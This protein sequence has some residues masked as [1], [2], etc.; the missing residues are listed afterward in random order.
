MRLSS[1]HDLI[2]E[3]ISKASD[4]DGDGTFR[5]GDP[6]DMQ[7]KREEKRQEAEVDKSTPDGLP[8]WMEPSW[9][10]TTDRKNPVVRK[11]K[12]PSE[13]GTFRGGD[14]EELQR[15]REEKRQDMINSG[16]AEE[17]EQAAQDAQ[18]SGEAQEEAQEQT[19]KDEEKEATK[20]IAVMSSQVSPVD[21][22]GDYTPR[23]ANGDPLALKYGYERTSDTKYKAPGP[24]RPGKNQ[25]RPWSEVLGIKVPMTNPI[26]EIRRYLGAGDRAGMEKFT[27]ILARSLDGATGILWCWRPDFEG[28]LLSKALGEAEAAGGAPAAQEAPAAAPKAPAAPVAAAA[29]QKPVAAPEKQGH[30]Y[31]KRWWEN[32]RWQYAYTGEMHPEGH[33]G[34]Q[35][36]GRLSGHTMDIHPETKAANVSSP[37]EAYHHSRAWHVAEGG[38]FPAQLFNKDTGK[39]EDKI[40][41]MPGSARGAGRRGKGD[42]PGK[43]KEIA[44]DEKGVP[45]FTKGSV[46]VYGPGQTP[47]KTNVQQAYRPGSMA[48]FERHLLQNQVNTEYDPHGQPW[49]H[50]RSPKTGTGKPLTQ[51]DTTS[52]YGKALAEA[53]GEEP[54]EWSRGHAETP[55]NLRNF[56]AKHASTMRFLKDEE[57]RG[58]TPPAERQKLKHTAGWEPTS[59]VEH[60]ADWR[61]RRGPEGKESRKPMK[62]TN[63]LEHGEHGTWT[64]GEA[65]TAVRTT[66]NSLGHEIRNVRMAPKLQFNS[67]EL[68]RKVKRDIQTE[69]M[70]PLYNMAAYGVLRP[71]GLYSGHMDPQSH[72]LAK[73]LA[74]HAIGA[75]VEHAINTYNPHRGRFQNHL[76]NTARGEMI[77]SLPQ[78]L[79]AA[80]EQQMREYRDQPEIKR[81]GAKAAKPKG[82]MQVSAAEFADPETGEVMRSPKAGAV[83]YQEPEVSWTA[84]PAPG[85]QARQGREPGGVGLKMGT[86]YQA[87]PEQMVARQQQLQQTQGYQGAAHELA[88][89]G[90]MMEPE[91]VEAGTTEDPYAHLAPP[92]IQ[93][94]RRK[95]EEAYRQRMA[96][97]SRPAA[98]EPE[99]EYA[100][101][102]ADVA[103]EEYEPDYSQYEYTRKAFD[104]LL[105]EE[106]LDVLAKAMAGEPMHSN[107]MK[108]LWREGEPGAHRHMWEDPQGNVVRG[109]NAPEG[110]PHHDPNA[111]PPQVHP[112]EPTP[113]VAP[114]FFDHRGRKLNRPA[115]EGAEVEDNNHYDPDIYHWAQRYQDP[116]TGKTEH[117]YFHRDCVKDPR[118]KFNEDLKHVDAQLE[119]VRQWYASLFQSQDPGERALGLIMALVDQAKMVAD[120]DESGLL[121]IKVKDVA[122]QG[123][124]I[125]FTYK[126]KTGG[127]HQS[128]VTMD[129]ESSAVLQEL[130]QG[131]SP[132][133]YLFQINGQRIPQSLLAQ[134][135]DQQ[136]GLLLNQFRVYHGSELFSK[137]FQNLVAKKANLKPNNLPAI[138]KQAMAQVA[139][140]LGHRG[141]S[142]HRIAQELY[143]DPLLVEALYI[144]AIHHH[145]PDL[146]KSYGTKPGEINIPHD[147]GGRMGRAVVTDHSGTELKLHPKSEW[148]GDV[149]HPETGAVHGSY[150]WVDSKKTGRWLHVKPASENSAFEG[151]EHQLGKAQPFHQKID[152]RESGASIGV[153][154]KMVFQGLPIS[155]ENPAG[156]IRRWEDH[157]TGETGETKMLYPYGFIRKTEGTDNGEVD[158]YVGPR[159][160]SDKVFVIHQMKGPDFKQYDEDKCMLGFDSAKQAKKAYLKHYDNP[161][162][163]GSMTQMTMR[164]F[165]SKVFGTHKH[166]YMITKDK[167]PGGLAE[168]RADKDFDFDSVM[169]G[170]KVE[171]EH[172]NDPS[173]AYEIAK[174]HL[175]EDPKYYQKLKKIEKSLAQGT[176]GPVVWHVTATHPDRLPDEQ[177]FSEW[178]HSHPLHEHDQEWA[179]FKQATGVSDPPLPPDGREYA[180]GGKGD[181]D[182]GADGFELQD[183]PDTSPIEEDRP[184]QGQDSN[185]A[186]SLLDSMI[187]RIQA[188]A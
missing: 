135:M 153:V 108:Y 87:G 20:S 157:A 91:A 34:I 72:D 65:P 3:M 127:P 181:L 48:D 54:G 148:H 56:V 122:P 175:T 62:T 45:K 82:A 124:T 81:Q 186:K 59:Y 12:D 162:F 76:L 52:K 6:V 171:M 11:A 15:K 89:G 29:P 47:G 25:R 173:V 31:V 102:Y 160:N 80:Q 105:F 66:I 104:D 40:I 115:P 50:W 169:E 140:M 92:E 167:I 90:H 96:A 130:M 23:D 27:N 41:H 26:Q 146:N 170:I 107:T 7:E 28:G 150:R 154:G 133:D 119:K 179:S 126:D 84:R 8:D 180:D 134:I 61:P 10:N 145:N 21:T 166:P 88:G 141:G 64:W 123:N 32:G 120:G 139:Q 111:G 37:E 55:D 71:R 70:G 78:F 112:H 113:D 43:Q 129:S 149:V 99:D 168:G 17:N 152:D 58:A 94:Q 161:N 118:R 4:S 57:E 51:F 151:S 39:T 106:A 79:S 18:D 136:F 86:G 97:M 36:M 74:S 116:E 95:E 110:H 163:F 177:A 131:K 77:R 156:S 176:Y 46:V 109:T 125:Q 103:G 83:P 13:E 137:V 98:K 63:A 33:H 75:S 144:A 30:Q 138:T 60:D 53:Y 142:F 101:R 5:G 68:E 158:V 49:L 38:S 100:Q 44:V 164:E 187:S 85:G 114:Q 1:S 183:E 19:E 132:E 117:N 24:I 188:V 22:F 178:I 42:Q 174:D 9:V 172:T 147:P 143:V 182:D 67:P 16:Q 155:I 14:P 69:N 35:H 121:S 2:N 128:V 73:E 165:K 159:R 93:A 184:Q 185:V